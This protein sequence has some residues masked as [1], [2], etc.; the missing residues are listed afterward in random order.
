MNELERLK[1]AYQ[2]AQVQELK[3]E[4][5]QWYRDGKFGMML[6]WGLYAIPGKGEWVMF[7]DRMSV[8]EYAHL[9][10][11]FT[12]ADFHAKEWAEAAKRAGMKYMVLTA[13]HHDGFCLFDS[14]VS[15]FNSM[16][17]AAG[18]DLIGEYVN[19]CR[20]AGLKVGIYY[21]PMDWRFPGYFFPN[22]YFDNAMEMRRQCQ[23]QLRELMTRYGKID[24]LWFDGEWLAHGGIKDGSQGW[25]RDK[26][27]GKDPI[28]F[29][30]N[31]FWQSE[32]TINMIRSLQPGI[33]INNRFG[34]KGD[35]QVRE[36]YVG[37]MRT[38]KPW[39][40][41][42]CLANSWGWIENAEMRTLTES[43]QNLVRA[44][45]RD[46]NTLLNV[47]P[48]P[49]GGLEKRFADR[50]AEI[51]DWLKEFGDTIYGTRGGPVLP[52]N[53]GGCTYRND[54]IYVHILEWHENKVVL[55]GVPGK[56]V[57]C[58]ARNAANVSLSQNEDEVVISVPLQNRDS[59]DTILELKV[60]APICWDGVEPFELG[61]YGLGDGLK[62][63]DKQ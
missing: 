13:R 40:S 39:E 35:F 21:S 22:L 31:Y 60:D 58:Q 41:V 15:S 26:D 17:A 24:L 6:H 47:S 11:E 33:M 34:W 18:R 57:S 56:V 25:Y 2:P 16:N 37:G 53:W 38:D 48:T 61:I 55:S 19:A 8:G 3:Q 12:A 59:I 54:T 23:E 50:L 52:G 4:D 30:V 44:A 29:H 42:D 62:K 51:G 10:E 46:G 9:A 43:V 49:T 45:V 14:K 27:F 5:M 20:E 63:E 36:R 32:E 28:F 1:A 7:N